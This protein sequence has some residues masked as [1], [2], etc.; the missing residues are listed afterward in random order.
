MASAAAAA[1]VATDADLSIDGSS[2]SSW[3]PGA[4][5]SWLSVGPPVVLVAFLWLVWWAPL[6]T[7]AGPLQLCELAR[8]C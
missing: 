3:S 6:A 7:V 2:C 8:S 5:A 1:F 4:L